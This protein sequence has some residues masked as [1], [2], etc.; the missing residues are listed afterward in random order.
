MDYAL[1][2]S[3]K[4]KASKRSSQQGKQSSSEQQPKK[5]AAN[6][7]AH[8]KVKRATDL[9]KITRAQLNAV[10]HWQFRLQQKQG[11]FCREIDDSLFRQ[12]L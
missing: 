4:D 8:G 7:K 5:E 12:P 1:P 11:H 9:S 10:S 6:D 2:K 3:S